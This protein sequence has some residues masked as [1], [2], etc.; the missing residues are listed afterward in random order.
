VTWRDGLRHA[1][2]VDP[3]GPAE[4]TQQQAQSVEWFCRQIARRKLSTPA[5]IGLEMSRPLNWLG[6]MTMHAFAPGVWAIAKQQS[7]EQYTHFAQYLE[8]RGAI[9]YICR[10]IEE[11]EA[12]RAASTSSDDAPA[13][14]PDDASTQTGN[15][16]PND[17]CA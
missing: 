7:Y 9:E 10:R 12:Q 13:A 8:R 14:R 11:M 15:M 16:G 1:F 6:A 3:P 17:D 2:A 5:L 4:P